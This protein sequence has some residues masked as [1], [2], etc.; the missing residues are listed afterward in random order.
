M[1]FRFAVEFGQRIWLTFFTLGYIL[2]KFSS[3]A[4]NKFF[5]LIYVIICAFSQCLNMIRSHN[6]TNQNVCTTQTYF[7]YKHVPVLIV[8]NT[9]VSVKIVCFT[10]LEGS[11][12]CTICTEQ[13]DWTKRSLQILRPQSEHTSFFCHSLWTKV[14][15]LVVP[16]YGRYR[17]TCCQWSGDESRNW[18]HGFGEMNDEQA[19][20]MWL[21]R[22]VLRMHI[23]EEHES[24]VC[25]NIQQVGKH[26]ERPAFCFALTA[27]APN[28]LIQCINA[29]L[30][31]VVV[32]DYFRLL[33]NIR[34]VWLMVERR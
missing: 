30:A 14:T 5:Q 13:N 9:K 3:L 19:P 34:N 22:V 15:T 25:T 4:K 16:L 23:G 21:G 17:W 26:C 10:Q 33:L 28:Q 12:M 8:L 6:Y 11:L 27:V 2:P 20:S 24:I 1:L 31:T 32:N 29:G 18:E 7:Y